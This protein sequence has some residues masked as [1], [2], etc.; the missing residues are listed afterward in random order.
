[1]LYALDLAR[2]DEPRAAVA[3][4]ALADVSEHFELPE[5]ARLFAA[6][7]VRGTTEHLEEIDACITGHATNW[8]LERMAAVDR[9]TLRIAAWEILYGKTPPAVAIDEAVSL[10][11]RFGGDRSSAFVNGILDALARAVAERVP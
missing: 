2:G 7:L 10:A 8:R 9:N 3:E 11:R 5:G 4:R 6:E 1:M